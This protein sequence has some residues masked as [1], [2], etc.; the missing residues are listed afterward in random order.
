MVGVSES[1]MPT[2]IAGAGKSLGVVLSCFAM[3]R[4]SPSSVQS[5]LLLTIESLTHVKSS[6]GYEGQK[7][8]ESNFQGTPQNAQ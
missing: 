6:D 4:G 1:S 2:P 3:K 5:G 7:K 8:S